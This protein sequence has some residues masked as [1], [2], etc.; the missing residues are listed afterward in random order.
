MIEYLGSMIEMLHNSQNE[1]TQCSIKYN[2]ANIVNINMGI[3][4]LYKSD[5]QETRHE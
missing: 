5:L 4:F 1:C 3:F 2:K